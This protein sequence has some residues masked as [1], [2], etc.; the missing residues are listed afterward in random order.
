MTK[1]LRTLK[2]I[3]NKAVEWG[4]ITRNPIAHVDPPKKLDSKPPRFFT[5]EELGLIYA[6]CS[7]KVNNGEGPQ[8]YPVHAFIW[9]LFANTGL[10][11]TEGLML[12]RKWVAREAMKILSTDEHRTKSG[13]WRE[14][15]LTEA[16]RHALAEL[17]RDG[18]Y[19][20]PRM[21][22]PSLSRAAIRDIRR[23]GVEDGSIH[24]FRHTY[25]SHLVMAGV[26]LRTVQ[27]LAG[28]STIAVTESY[29]HLSPDYL[30]NA[31]RAISL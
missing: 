21:T 2:A 12:R 19:V 3:L 17:P 16:A 7:A 10:R 25:C 8:P 5:L 31:G 22:L 18:D 14:V 26:P 6:A 9:R 27:K 11:R 15:P 13:K 28:H 30:R 29:S 4:D 1:E 24:T 20:L 23:A